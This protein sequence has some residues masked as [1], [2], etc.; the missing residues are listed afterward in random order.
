M[1]HTQQYTKSTLN[2]ILTAIARGEPVRA[3]TGEIYYTHTFESYE[4]AYIT[5]AYTCKEGIIVIFIQQR[6]ERC[7]L[8]QLQKYLNIMILF[9]ISCRL[10]MPI[11]L[12]RVFLASPK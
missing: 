1:V 4:D 9:I 8:K 11:G 5:H 12:T 6:C 3:G 10:Y 7:I 2:H